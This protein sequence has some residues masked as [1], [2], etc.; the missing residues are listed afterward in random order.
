MIWRTFFYA[1]KISFLCSFGAFGD[2]FP[3]PYNTEKEE[4]PPMSA[5]EAA[6]SA[7]LPD[8]FRLEVFAAEPDV[9]QP[10]SIAF[11]DAGRLWVAECYTFAER[12]LRWDLEL[13]DRVLVLE[14]ADGDGTMDKRTVFW[15]EGKRLTSAIPGHG[16]VWV[17]CAPQLLFIPDK[18]N[19]LVP[20][21][22]PIVMLDGFDAEHIGHNIVN[23]LKWG[24]D[25]WLYGRHGITATSPV[26]K[27]GTPKA[28]RTQLNCSIWRFHPETHEFEVFCD[29]GTNPWGLDWDE[30]GQ[31]FY[32][33]TVIGH[34]WHAIPGAYYTRMF[35][36]HLNPYVYEVVPHTADHY[37]WDTGAEK[38]ND[39]RNGVTGSTSALG[40]GHAHMGCLIYQGGVWPKEY[41]GDLFACNLHGRR[42]N[43]DH[44]KREGVGYVATHGKDFLMM[45][46]P[47]FRGLDLITGPDGQV[48]M[49]DWSDTGECHD[50]DAIHRTSGRIYR[51]V[52]DGP[53]KGNPTM[54]R[55]DWLTRR[56]AGEY[57]RNALTKLLSSDEEATAAMAVRW[58][59]E[60][61]GDE[62]ETADVFAN[63]VSET[64]PGMV[65]MELAA[66]LQ[67]LPLKHRAPLAKRLAAL[68]QDSD[69]RQ[70]SL[71]I[72][73]GVEK[74][75]ASD[76]MLGV[77]IALSSRQ[78]TVTRLVTRRLASEM[79]RWENPVS[80]LLRGSQAVPA[81]IAEQVAVGMSQGLEGWVNAKEPKFWKEFTERI[82]RSGD[83]DLMEKVRSLAVLFGDG[84]VREDLIAAAKDTERDSEVRRA[85]LASLLRQPEDDLLDLLKTWS[86]D[87]VLARDAIRGL[88]LYDAPGVSQR[89]INFWKRNPAFRSI[90][91]D[92]LVARPSYARDLLAFV[93][94]GEIPANAIS[95]SQARQIA[96]LG[97]EKLSARLVELW[98]AI[99]E[100]PAEK[101]KELE[102]WK[103]LLT[104]EAVASSDPV[105]GKQ[106]FAQ[107][108][109]ACHVLYGEGGK[110]G[111]DLTGSDRHNVDYILE[112]TINPSDVIP[113]DY[114]LTVFTLKDGRVVSG[115]IAAETDK[116]IT[117]QS[118]AGEM[119]VSAA[120]VD[121]RETLPI[122]LM[123]EGLF[124]ALGEDAVKDLV[125]YLM[126]DGPVGE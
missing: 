113:A 68:A 99:R 28:R 47:W 119:I 31:L 105:R 25:G 50:N 112:S 123:P 63:L 22:E 54:D 51:I 32:T 90:A 21:G 43:R 10:I 38:W 87:K 13:C 93:E 52:Y 97:D 66:A 106:F 17:T 86:T 91:I 30:N 71:L 92:S 48:W 114:R 53:E 94:K 55:P 77:E 85:A 126:T 15:D 44:L 26:G 100:T 24:P 46:D 41:H 62:K 9:Q 80:S 74:V 76:P 73:Y 67:R 64:T 23:G 83:E 116:A 11:D 70:Q 14:D 88:A 29:G 34:L 20:D 108:C 69:D 19:D 45:E 75:V 78:P 2:E 60:D 12:P 37:H 59:S 118:A 122:S 96:N 56:A 35:G 39:I 27:P 89:M 4:A 18:D 104:K 120:E 57:D 7:K 110:I 125:A 58:L 121:K 65:R 8:G 109:G 42:V 111:P 16:G 81:E 103:S 107:S 40:G 6:K 72:W 84:R 33:N 115:V 98:G 117:V 79:E 61:W 36:A 124:Q 95:P 5:A 1:L 102:K 49:N 101:K 3:E 82:H